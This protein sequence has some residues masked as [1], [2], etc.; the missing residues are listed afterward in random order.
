VTGL[1]AQAKWHRFDR[2]DSTITHGPTKRYTSS[3]PVNGGNDLPNRSQRHFDVLHVRHFVKNH[4]LVSN[5]TNPKFLIPGRVDGLDMDVL[6]DC[7]AVLQF[8]G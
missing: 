7:L 1:Q 2:F 8:L 6:P 3:L 5:F 4:N